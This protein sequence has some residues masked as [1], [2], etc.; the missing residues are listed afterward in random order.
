MLRK[1]LAQVGKTGWAYILDRATG[2]PLIG[3]DEKPVPQEPRQATAATQPFPVGDALVPQQIDIAP[4]GHELVNEGR[5]FTPFVEQGA[6]L[7]AA[8]RAR[9]GRRVPTIPRTHWLYVC[10]NETGNGARA[11]TRQFAPPTFKESFRGGDYVGAG[12]AEQWHLLG[13]RCARRTSD[14]VAE[15]LEG[16]LLQ[17]LAGDRGRPRVRRP[18][19][20]AAHRARCR[21]TARGCGNSRPKRR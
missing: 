15:A 3:I 4:E 14:R 13:A 9:T 19:R 21:A 12:A 1:G 20:R 5:I 16:R 7:D 6:D 8:R 2:K 10:A 18:Q 11:D 17:R